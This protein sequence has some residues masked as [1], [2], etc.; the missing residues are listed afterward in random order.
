[1]YGLPTIWLAAL[2][3]S[4][5]SAGA[6]AGASAVLPRRIA[7][8]FAS[9]GFA[10]TVCGMMAVSACAL[11]GSNDPFVPADAAGILPCRAAAL[12]SAG[13]GWSEFAFGSALVCWE[14]E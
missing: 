2:I 11:S 14:R 5:T 13:V 6:S 4:L 1:M 9:C 12:I 3:A 10:G 8:L 7:R